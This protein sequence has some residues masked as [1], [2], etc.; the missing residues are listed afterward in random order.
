MYSLT[1]A[2]KL[3]LE[4]YDLWTNSSNS[5]N[6]IKYNNNKVRHT[7]WVLE[8]W[9]N[10]LIKIKENTTLMPEIINKVEVCFILHD[11]GRFFQNDWKE[12]FENKNYDHWDKSYEIVKNNNY[13]SDICL[14]IKY[15]NKFT[16]NWIYEEDEYQEMNDLE[17]EKTIFLLNILKD[18]DKLQSMIYSLFD[19]EALLG[20]DKTAKNIIEWD[21]SDVNLDD[22]KNHKLIFRPN[23]KTF[24]DYNLWTLSFIIDL[25]FHESLKMLDFYNYTEDALDKIQ[26]SPWV[27]KES[28]EIIRK[29]IDSF[30]KS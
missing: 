11:V 5:E 17:K 15:H 4:S 8:T 21:I 6:I 9:R 24:W 10:L 2:T 22:F 30:K 3:L 13:S 12:V 7:F 25:N 29:S 26:K 19:N 28:M 27:S 20:T 18:S 1:Q 16:I 23:I 14:A